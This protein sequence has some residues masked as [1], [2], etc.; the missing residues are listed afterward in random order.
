MLKLRRSILVVFYFFSLSAYGQFTGT[1]QVINNGKMRFGNGTQF[2]INAAGNVE[3]PFYFSTVLNNWR[4]LTYSESAL[5]NYPLDSRIGVGGDGTNNWNTN[6]VREYNPTMV[7]Q[8]FDTSGFSVVGGESFGTIIVKGEIT[9]GT[10]RLELTNAYRVRQ[11]KNFV[12][13]LTT[14]KN[15]GLAQATNIRYWIGT[16]D[17]YV[18]GTDQPTKIRGN[19]NDGTF[20]AITLTTQRASALRITT[21][22]EGILFF[23]TSARGNNVHAG[24]N[25]SQNISTDQDPETAQIT[26]TNDGSYSMFVRMNNLG[27]NESDTFVW[28]YAAAALNEL[29][30][31]IEEVFDSSEETDWDTDGILNEFDSCPYTA[32]VSALDGCPWSI[33]LGNNYKSNT[34]SN[35]VIVANETYHCQLFENRFFNTA[36]HSGDDPEPEVGDYI[37]WNNKHSFPQS[38]MF[39]QDGFAYM[40]MRSFNKIIEV[41][42]T[43][44]LITAIY[45]CP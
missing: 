29:D 12:Q 38:F 25:A 28:Y 14:I 20:E 33:D 41:R 9:I 6:G 8:V 7:N 30:D 1:N 45:A 27:I 24:Y 18:G 26:S 21:I 44:G 17:D 39:N 13:V 31:I 16:R 23:T 37:I 35:S 11:D 15:I 43:D 34:A 32:G 10:A 3:Q 22:S 40:K 19:L 4:Q 5:V 42:K 2:S 36:Y